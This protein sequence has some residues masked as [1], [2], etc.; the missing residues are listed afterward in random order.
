MSPAVEQPTTF[1][2]AAFVADLHDAGMTVTLVQP[3]PRGGEAVEPLRY[4]I[5]PNRRY[6]EVM[7]RWWDAMEACPDA[8]ERV[9]AALTAMREE[10]P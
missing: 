1:D 6:T 4:W 7:G 5:Q 9:T 8:H 3:I 2:A 10:S